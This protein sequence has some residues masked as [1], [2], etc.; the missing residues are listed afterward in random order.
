M[1]A[2]SHYPSANSHQKNVGGR[3]QAKTILCPGKTW[4]QLQSRYGESRVDLKGTGSLSPLEFDR[5]TVQPHHNKR[6]GKYQDRL[7]AQLKRCYESVGSCG[8]YLGVRRRKRVGFKIWPLYLGK[9]TSLNVLI[10]IGWYTFG[11]RNS[12]PLQLNGDPFAGR[13]QPSPYTDFTNDLQIC[14]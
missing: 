13:P 1:Q 8:C 12:L 6:Q 3:H 2:Y 11:N 5:P 9:S 4:Y 14:L 10:G 7:S